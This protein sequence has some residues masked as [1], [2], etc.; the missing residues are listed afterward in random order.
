MF[1]DKNILF[2]YISLGE[3]V[4]IFKAKIKEC[5]KNNSRYHVIHRRFAT[6]HGFA[7]GK[8]LIPYYVP[9]SDANKVFNNTKRYTLL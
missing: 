5:E 9:H 2:L 4:Y 6:F 1:Y 8:L 7:L 3:Q